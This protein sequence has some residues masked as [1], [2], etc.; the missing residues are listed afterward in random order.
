MRDISKKME[1]KEKVITILKEPIIYILAIC[2]IFQIII[3]GTVPKHSVANDSESYINFFQNEGQKSKFSRT[4]V[5]PCFIE[6]IRRIVGEENLL[7]NVAFAQKILFLVT[8]VL[9]YGCLKKVTKNK[10]IITLFTLIF[11]ITPYINLWNV[12]ILTEAL[13]IFEM[14]VLAF[15]TL[16]YLEKP[17]AIV[18]GSI[19]WN[20]ITY[21]YDEASIYIYITN[22][23]FILDV[24][25]YL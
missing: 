16:K 13:A 18:A 15:L 2:V 17:N 19:R 8:L 25:I 14:V 4:P 1:L 23:Y 11:G 5:Y 24:E 20:N 6:F 3:Y 7:D 21:D 22:I 12:M 10:K 9:F